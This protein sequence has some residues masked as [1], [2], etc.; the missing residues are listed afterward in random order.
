MVGE[1]SVGIPLHVVIVIVSAASLRHLLHLLDALTRLQVVFVG[2]ILDHAVALVVTLVA[3]LLGLF[4]RGLQRLQ[5]QT[6]HLFLFGR[7]APSRFFFQVF[8]LSFEP[9]LLFLLPFEPELVLFLGFSVGE[10]DL[11]L[12]LLLLNLDS[13][14]RILDGLAVLSKLELLL[15]KLLRSLLVLGCLVSVLHSQFVLL[16]R[17]SLEDAVLLLLFKLEGLEALAVS[18][19]FLP[20]DIFLLLNELVNLSI[21]VFVLGFQ[22]NGSGFNLA[23]SFFQ[24]RFFV[25][26]LG[27]VSVVKFFQSR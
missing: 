25:H 1:R 5:P 22:S 14:K 4:A 26:E 20:L 11:I 16:L 10:L 8:P 17:F 23:L 12:N 21:Y 9:L 6:F 13:I 24:L 15:E 19:F 18:L 3:S 27:D 2:D 7:L